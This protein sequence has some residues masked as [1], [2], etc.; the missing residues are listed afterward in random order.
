MS[1]LFNDTFLRACRKERVAHIP[2]WY[3]RQAGRY[4][5]DYR[6]IREKY[7]FFEISRHP[8]VCAQVTRMPVD[9]LGVDA[10]ILFA[11]IMTPLKARGLD[12]S[13][14]EG[15]GPVIKQPFREE[16]DLQR[17]RLLEPMRDLPY[18]LETIDRL[19]DQLDVPLIG[20]AGAPFTLASYLIE[21][22]PSKNY[23]VT[24]AFMYT[25]PRL[26]QALMDD[27]AEMTIQYLSA[28][29]NAGAQ[30]VQVF[31]SWV[32]SLSALDYSCYIAPTMVRIFN[33]L[34][35]TGAVTLYFSAGAGHLVQEWTK[36]PVDVL[37]VDWRT[38]VAQLNEAHVAQAIQGTLDPS[39]LL[40]PWP[41]LQA[42]A[43]QILQQ[44]SGR[45]GYIFNLGH[46]VFPDVEEDT[47]RRLTDY[48]HCYSVNGRSESVSKFEKGC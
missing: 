8:E 29:I 28:Q 6:A 46:G 12:V 11:D 35:Q 18:V 14:I 9:H 44:L 27:L 38:D 10:A 31:D 30:A 22:G 1:T 7:S 19:H 41:L 21:G 25:H 33:A 3:M 45:P 47:L 23:H 5:A 43:E 4:Q 13:I 32:G 48:V 36:L 40:A 42:R 2:V 15:V 26:W 20:F 24:K 37:S 39:L 34:R 16:K 17:L